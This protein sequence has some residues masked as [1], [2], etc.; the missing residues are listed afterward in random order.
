MSHSDENITIY[1]TIARISFFIFLFFTIFGT[2]MPFREEA[3]KISEISSSN[4]LNQIVYSTL[5]MTSFIVILNKR[6]ESILLI[7]EE[8]IL[9]LFLIWCLLSVMWSEYSFVSFKRF[10]QVLTTVLVS[11]AFLLHI[12]SSKKIF[13]YLKFIFFIYITLSILAILIVP[14]AKQ[15]SGEWRGLATQKN[16]LG[17]AALVSIIVWSYSLKVDIFWRRYLAYFMLFIS[18]ILLVGARSSTSLLTLVVLAT[19]SVTKSIDNRLKPLKI[20]RIF[21]ILFIIS[22]ICSAVTII[23]LGQHLIYYLFDLIGEDPTFT[24]RTDIWKAIFEIARKNL[25]FGCGFGGFWIIDRL[26]VQMLYKTFYFLPNQSHNGYIDILNETGLIGLS[27]LILMIA[28]YFRGLLRLKKPRL[29]AL[30]VICVLIV[31]ITE[32]TLFRQG[33]LTGRLFILY[34]LALYSDLINFR[35]NTLGMNY[36]AA[37]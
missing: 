24:G 33:M 14:G 36:P 32:S 13:P 8:K 17:Q 34:Y 16:Q 9:S 22:I 5:F 19:L 35:K 6:K 25:V 4:I 27:L 3:T 10:F 7:K 2:G 37:R 15:Y 12:D 23:L 29:G 20:G 18:I 30:I 11:I 1:D 31:N 26:D 21:S 28:N